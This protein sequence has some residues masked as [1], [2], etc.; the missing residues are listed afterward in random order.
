MR[1]G[2]AAVFAGH[3][4]IIVNRGGATSDDVLEL[5]ARMKAAVQARF[6]EELEAEVEHLAT[7]P[8]SGAGNGN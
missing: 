7:P 8:R 6:G 5:A 4:N 3:A 2:G 1:E